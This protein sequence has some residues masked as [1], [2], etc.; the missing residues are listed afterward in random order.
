MVSPTLQRSWLRRG[1]TRRANKEMKLTK[2]SV[3]E[4]RSLSPVFDGQTEGSDREA[5]G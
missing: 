4:L 5:G 2:P 3:L 1:K